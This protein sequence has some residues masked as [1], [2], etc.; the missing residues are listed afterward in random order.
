MKMQE[1]GWGAGSPANGTL[2]G[3][4][5]AQEPS[6]LLFRFFPNDRAEQSFPFGRFKFIQAF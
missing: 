1:A 6:D 5:L 2:P 3:S 4:A